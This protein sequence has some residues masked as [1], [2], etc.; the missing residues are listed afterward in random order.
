MREYTVR[1]AREG[2]W[3][4]IRV[5][6]IDGLTQARRL[7]EVEDMARSLIAVTLDVP[8][9]EFAVRV[10]LEAIEDMRVTERLDALHAEEDAAQRAQARY[11]DNQRQL[12]RDLAS[13]GVTVRDVGSVLGV[14]FQRAQ[15]LI[16]QR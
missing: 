11:R 9:E 8:A 1:V 2:K 14:S 5:P 10:E 12:A 3:W 13:K 6:D 16:S 7:S 15:Q 4:M